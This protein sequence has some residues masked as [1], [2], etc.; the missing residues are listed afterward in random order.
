MNLK[1][2]FPACLSE[3]SK[4]GHRRLIAML[5][6][7]P[8][9]LLALTLPSCNLIGAA[10]GLG[11]TKLQFGCIPQGEMIDTPRGPIAIE[12][13]KSGDSIVGYEGKPVYIAQIHQY[14]EDPT[15]SRYLSIHFTN[16]SKVTTSL[17]HRIAG[18]PAADLHVGDVCA[19]QTV[20]RIE[21][22]HG[23][24][25]SFDLLTEDSGYRIAGIPVNSMIEEMLGR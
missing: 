18:I 20:S 12:N 21:P 15:T 11:L 24:S 25:R 23:V 6:V 14:R 10:L 19:S 5:W 3:S 1:S 4:N 16:G 9:L 8:V 13:L 22:V 2:I 17:R 7:I